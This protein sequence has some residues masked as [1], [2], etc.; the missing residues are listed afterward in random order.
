MEIIINTALL[1]GV[2]FCVSVLT[3]PGWNIQ[4]R[5]ATVSAVSTAAVNSASGSVPFLQKKKHVV[6]AL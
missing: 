3:A 1:G 6:P 2:K 5:N 4:L